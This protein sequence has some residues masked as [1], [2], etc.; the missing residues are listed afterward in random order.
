[1]K[2]T[3]VHSRSF[4]LTFFLHRTNTLVLS[5]QSAPSTWLNNPVLL[6]I[7]DSPKTTWASNY[8]TQ[9]TQHFENIWHAKFG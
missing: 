4:T 5:A 9:D 8:T 6:P 7:S 1:M 2:S 3:I